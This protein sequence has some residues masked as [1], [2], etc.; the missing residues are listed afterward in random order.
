MVGPKSSTNL[1][2]FLTFLTDLADD[3]ALV[4]FILLYLHQFYS[5]YYFILFAFYQTFHNYLINIKGTVYLVFLAYFIF[6]PVY[7]T[8]PPTL[9]PSLSLIVLNLP[10]YLPHYLSSYLSIYPNTYFTAFICYTSFSS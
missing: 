3:I 10:P 4:F 7:S 9:S 6:L 8:R 5:H 1:T 2:Y